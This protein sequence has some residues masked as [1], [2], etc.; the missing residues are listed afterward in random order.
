MRACM[1]L[2]RRAVAKMSSYSLIMLATD[3]GRTE[4]GGEERTRVRYFNLLW[5]AWQLHLHQKTGRWNTCC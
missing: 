4:R 2:R 3:G 1:C 5:S